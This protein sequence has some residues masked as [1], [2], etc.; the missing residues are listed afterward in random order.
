M[1]IL[2]SDMNG[3][4]S[5][6][7]E[8]LSDHPLCTHPYLFQM[9]PDIGRQRKEEWLYSCPIWVPCHFNQCAGCS[10]DNWKNMSLI[11]CPSIC[12]HNTPKSVLKASCTHRWMLQKTP[13][14]IAAGKRLPPSCVC[15][16]LW[17]MP[18]H[19][20]CCKYKK[21]VFWISNHCKLP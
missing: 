3:R 18:E 14:N 16:S 12:L 15:W 13:A 11:Y 9:L 7:S 1:W 8:K 5:Q 19:D 21:T 6:G 10:S 20:G 17:V 4:S 2:Q